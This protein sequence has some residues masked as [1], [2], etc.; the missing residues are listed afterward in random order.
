MFSE[1]RTQTPFF[2][3]SEES[4]RRVLGETKEVRAKEEGEIYLSPKVIC[5]NEG[6][7]YFFL[8]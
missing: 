1:L 5:L 3:L 7:V 8:S 4:P 2:P 6:K